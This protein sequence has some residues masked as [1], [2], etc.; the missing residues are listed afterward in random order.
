MKFTL[1][2]TPETFGSLPQEMREQVIARL[3]RKM[4][5]E[6]LQIKHQKMMLEYRERDLSQWRDI[7][8]YAIG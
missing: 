7:T 4:E 6:R 1:E 2:V 5:N 3:P 8:K